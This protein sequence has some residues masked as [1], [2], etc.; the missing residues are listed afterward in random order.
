M[1]TI[2]L[3]SVKGTPVTSAEVDANFNNLNIAKIERT[4]LVSDANPALK[5]TQTGTGVALLIE[6]SASTDSTPFVIDA[7]GSVA[8]G[9]TTVTDGIK[10]D[11]VG[12]LA[13]TG[14]ITTASTIA[15]TGIITG[16]GG[17][18][19]QGSTS[20][21]GTFTG[22]SNAD[23]QALTSIISAITPA[24]L[25]HAF[26]GA[27]SSLGVSGYQILPS[28]YILQNVTVT[29][30][31]TPT[32]ITW[33]L[34]FPTA[35]YGAIAGS[36]ANGVVSSASVYSLTLGGATGLA[37]GTNQQFTIWAIGK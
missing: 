1:A 8:I 10:L 12:A 23:A 20:V 15:A 18:S 2:V 13:T 5:I 27:K 19:A 32:T 4:L 17:S 25:K 36:N 35:V 29:L 6:D 26:E 33:P 22:A 11:V 24:A 3:R 7:A 34:A 14:A 28:G 30:T 9:K 37:S 21:R 31:T 16:A